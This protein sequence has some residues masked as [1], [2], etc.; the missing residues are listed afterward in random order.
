MLSAKLKFLLRSWRIFFFLKG[1]RT[2]VDEEDVK[3]M[4]A[5]QSRGEEG[6]MWSGM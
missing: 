2:G 4:E 3:G 1:Y 6:K 5:M